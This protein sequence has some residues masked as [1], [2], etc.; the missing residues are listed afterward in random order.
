[1]ALVIQSAR[2]QFVLNSVDDSGLSN[3]VI[4]IHLKSTTQKFRILGH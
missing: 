2:L 4:Y 3:T 1:M